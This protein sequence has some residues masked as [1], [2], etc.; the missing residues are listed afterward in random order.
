CDLRGI[1]SIS[2]DNPENCAAAFLG[3]L[4]RRHQIRTH[5]F[6]Q[7]A[8]A[9]RQNK[10]RVFF[11]ESASFKPF[12]ENGSPSLIVGAGGQLRDIIG[13]CVAF[14]ACNLSEIVDRVR[15]VR[16]ATSDAQDKK[17]SSARAYGCQ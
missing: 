14:H 4:Q 6:F 13:G 11:T 8:S 12:G 2:T 15:S 7:A 5:I 1:T 16:R 17:P 9:H 3:Q 10:K